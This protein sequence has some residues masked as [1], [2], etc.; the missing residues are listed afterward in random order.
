M[1]KCNSNDITSP[2]I[3]TQQSAINELNS[4][5]KT[6][7]NTFKSPDNNALISCQNKNKNL[8]NQLQSY[9]NNTNVIDLNNCSIQ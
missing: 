3:K 6:C 2:L 4:K 7:E 8:T 1:T 5:L 9:Q